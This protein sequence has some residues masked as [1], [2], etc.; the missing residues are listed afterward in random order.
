MPN[1]ITMSRLGTTG[2]WG[3]Q[4]IQ[5]AY[6]RTCA[7]RY[8][9]DYAVPKWAGQ[10][11]FGHN[12]PAIT[13]Q[14]PPA[15]E[16]Y[17][18]TPYE[19]C[20]GY[21]T[22]PSQGAQIDHDFI[23]WAQYH[24]S[25]YAPDREFIQGLYDVVSPERERVRP[26]IEQL[27]ERGKTLV[28]FHLRRSDAGRMIF[29]LTPVTWFL[30]W[31]RAHWHAL[32]EPVLYIATEEPALVRHFR[33][34]NPV[35]M[36]DVGVPARG[37]PHGYI[38]PYGNR[39]HHL[40]QLDFFPDWYVMQNADIVVAADSTFSF[41]AAWTSRTVQ[42]YWRAR[43]STQHFETVDPW[44]GDVSWREHLNDYPGIPGTQ[45]DTN[46]IYGDY[47]KNYSARYPSVPLDPADIAALE[48][49]L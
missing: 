22:P 8:G 36:E 27:R 19:S 24:T 44:D 18:P 21:P 38:Y 43:L 47:W 32:V 26:V 1:L 42:E 6:I 25:W 30:L 12:D 3:N 14:L 10:Y 41:S 13:R 34:Y 39:Y 31:L 17:A 45:T 7:K 11:L 23:G 20:F 48:K 16:T 28:V 4:V 37:A 9:C 49:P 33:Y 29:F 2:Q 5:Y 15:R 46:P 40:R 35:T